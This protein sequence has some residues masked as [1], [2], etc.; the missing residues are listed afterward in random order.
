MRIATFNVNGIRAAERRGLDP[1]LA[2]SGCD[3]VALQEVRC[4][5][6][7]LPQPLLADWFVAHDPGEIA[8]RNGVMVLTRKP[9]TDVRMGFG[10]REFDREGR[11]LEVDLAT[12]D[13]EI[14][15]LTIAS[16]YLPKGGYPV[17]EP[18]KYARKVRFLR[19][20]ARQLTHSRRRAARAGREFLLL[21]DLNI[22]HTNADLKNWRSNKGSPGFLP[23]EREWLGHQLSPRTLVDVVRRLH[24]GQD[25]PYSWW[26]WRG[27]SW[28]NDAGWRI[29]YHLATP[30]LARR[31]TAGWTDRGPSY[32]ARM[33][34]HAPVVV[35]YDL[36]A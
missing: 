15:G 23:E 14:G 35:D 13:P 5:P 32:E 7:A 3:V 16:L 19:S 6:D 27:R 30:G 22:A 1:W 36:S 17:E 2:A 29:D 9:V 28:D 26:S 24:P 8:G 21:G 34:D 33:S 25:G 11:Y 18:E 10:S 12:H 31:A 20:F 4:P